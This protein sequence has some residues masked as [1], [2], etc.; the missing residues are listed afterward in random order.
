M[1]L[2]MPFK[3]PIIFVF[4][5]L[6]NS[7]SF[8]QQDS[9]INLTLDDA[10]KIALANNRDVQIALQDLKKSDAQIDEAYADVWP[11]INA[12]GEYDRNIKSPVLFIPP[13]TPFNPSPQTV[14][15]SLGAKNSYALSASLNQTLFSLKVNTAISI[16]NDYHNYFKYA[17]KSTEDEV[18]LQVKE[19]FYTIL[20]AKDLINVS[21]KSYEVA[22]A[23]F[24]NVKSQFTHGVSSEY[25][26]L[27]AEVQL[28]N[29]DPV[30]IQAKNNF[31]LAKNGLKNLLTIDLKK[32]INVIGEFKLEPVDSVLMQEAADT[33][34]ENNP[35]LTALDFQISVLEKNVKL[36]TAGYF[37]TL[38]GFANYLWQ[39]QDNTFDFSN[40]LWAN[41]ITVGLRLSIPVFDGFRKNARIEQ[42]IVDKT[43][44][45]L[46]KL[47]AEEGL[48]IQL[49]QA[50]LKMKEARERVLA[51]GKS[52]NQAER[53]VEIAES[54]YNN[55]IG[56]QLE[57]LDTQSS[58]TMAQTNYSQ[59][60]YD[61]LIAKAQWEKIIGSSNTNLNN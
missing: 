22:K 32:E 3:L 18:I 45:E 47:K 35:M 50:Q 53:A 30:L 16:A 58:L 8:P 36:E 54:R 40:Y 51:Q 7:F 33:F 21:Q 38:S 42:A 59:A 4:I 14:T 43:K 41:T 1:L 37:P 12:T 55:G 23:N 28:A 9:V 34:I 27:R 11:S 19:A 52:L 57:I 2:K 6:L 17:E 48:R 56:T 49:V 20:L 26:L 24:D 10:I 61:Y 39:T 5:I 44:L 31:E 15:F 29:V 46:T 13:N 25:D 60:I